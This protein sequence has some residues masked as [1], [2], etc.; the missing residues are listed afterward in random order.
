[1]VKI[2]NLLLNKLVLTSGFS[3]VNYILNNYYMFSL[4]KLHKVKMV[5]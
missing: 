3:F 2:M 4:S 1:M 5:V